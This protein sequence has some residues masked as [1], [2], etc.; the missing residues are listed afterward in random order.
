MCNIWE[1]TRAPVR[2]QILTLVQDAGLIRRRK[3]GPVPNNQINPFM[4]EN[5]WFAKSKCLLSFVIQNHRTLILPSGWCFR[6]GV[7]HA[8]TRYEATPQLGL[9]DSWSGEKTGACAQRGE[10]PKGE[11][12]AGG[13]VRQQKGAFS[14]ISGTG[15][16]GAIAPSLGPAA[17]GLYNHL[18][19]TSL[20]RVRST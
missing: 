9:T 4:T 17:P 8:N 3:E 1:Q 7:I 19:N 13:Q 16:Q 14:W 5:T 20:R 12:G 11:R 10:N 6:C 18:I 2:T 15:C